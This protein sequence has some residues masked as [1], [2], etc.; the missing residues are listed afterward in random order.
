[1]NLGSDKWQDV[2][3]VISLLKLFF[4]KLPESL[5]TNGNYVLVDFVAIWKWLQI[6]SR[7]RLDTC[8]SKH[9]R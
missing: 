2:N 6:D 4:R 9:C 1:M 7:H 5:V 8:H 3:V